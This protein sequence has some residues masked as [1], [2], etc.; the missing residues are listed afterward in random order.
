VV[1]ELDLPGRQLEDLEVTTERNRLFVDVKPQ[2]AAGE[3]SYLL[4]ER[5]EQSG[6]AEF[7]LPFPVA[8][9]LTDVAY[10]HGVLRIEVKKPAEEQ[11]RKLNVRQG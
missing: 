6:R 1:L 7:R 3:P 10:Q 2:S 4:R 11:P 8:A 9:E 5:G